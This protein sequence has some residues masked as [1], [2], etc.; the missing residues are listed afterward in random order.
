[1][2]ASISIAQGI[3]ESACG[4]SAIARLTNNHFGVTCSGNVCSRDTL[5]NHCMKFRDGFFRVYRSDKGSWLHH[6][7]I[8]SHGQ[9]EWLTEMG[10]DY[11]AWAHGLKDAGYAQDAGYAG[12]LIKIIEA[13][14]L[15]RYDLK[16]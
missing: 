1:M 10:S 6:A 4:T 14:G 2:P 8:I 11:R 15:H 16:P 13:Y 12:K 3:L 7:R 9:Y 5:E